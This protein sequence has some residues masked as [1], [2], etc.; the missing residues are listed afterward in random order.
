MMNQLSAIAAILKASTF[1]YPLL[2][3]QCGISSLLKLRLKFV[4]LSTSYGAA[5][6]GAILVDQAMCYGCHLRHKLIN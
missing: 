1:K 4:G 5:S 2:D 3:F 6:P